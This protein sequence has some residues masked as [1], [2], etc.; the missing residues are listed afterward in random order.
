MKMGWAIK[1]LGDVLQ[2]QNGYAFDSKSF[3]T[4]KGLPLVRIRSL[5]AGVETETRF[6]GQYDEKYV[7]K[8]GDLLIGM[9]G[10]FGCYEWKGEPALLNQ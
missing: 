5:K 2:I 10:E 1:Q 3:N 7:V 9:D 8:A 4:T 6:D